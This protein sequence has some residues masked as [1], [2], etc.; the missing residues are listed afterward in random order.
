MLNYFTRQ[1]ALRILNFGSLFALLLPIALYAQ[2]P[3]TITKKGYTLHFHAQNPDFDAVQQ[4]RLQ[5]VFFT[6]YPKL[7]KDFNKNSLKEVTI[8][9]DTAYDGV[10]YAH[11]GKIVIAQAWMEKMPEDIDVVTHEVMHI[12]QAYPPR[13]GSGWLVEGIAD[14]VRYKY[15][16]NNK[17]ANW[18]LPELKDDHHYTKSYRISARFLDWIENNK[19]KGAVKQLDAA[20][21]EKTYTPE[22]WVNL[23]GMELDALWDAYVAANK[24]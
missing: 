9:I 22:I 4:K 10:A 3:Q 17:A 12:V 13:S 15:G 16:V 24:A 18:S 11:N 14:Y 20:M 8:T 1:S 6:N 2:Q 23:T 19:K 21:R 5:N 7:V